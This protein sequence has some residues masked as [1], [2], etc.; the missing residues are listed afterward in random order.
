MSISES[1]SNYMTPYLHF[2]IAQPAAR[3]FRRGGVLGANTHTLG[4]GSEASA[5]RR[6]EAGRAARGRSPYGTCRWVTT[7]GDF[8]TDD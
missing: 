4:R 7:Y 5:N 3:C 8:R 2:P 6:G 1:G